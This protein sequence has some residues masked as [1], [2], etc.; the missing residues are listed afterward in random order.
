MNIVQGR[1]EDTQAF[2]MCALNLQQKVLF[3]SQEANSKLQA[4]P[5]LVQT[6]FLLALENGLQ[7]EALRVKLRPFLTEPGI[8]DEVLIERFSTAIMSEEERK[9]KLLQAMH[10]QP[11]TKVNKV[12]VSESENQSPAASHEPVSKRS[13][14]Q[15]QEDKLMAA[16]QAVQQDVNALKERFNEA[17]QN[18]YSTP[19]YQSQGP[20]PRNHRQQYARKWGPPHP[21]RSCPFCREQ[22]LVSAVTT[23]F[24][25]DQPTTGLPIVHTQTRLMQKHLQEMANSHCRGTGNGWCLFTRVPQVCKLLYCVRSANKMAM[26][27]MQS[28]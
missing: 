3:V 21:P 25:V 13:K 15:Q 8:T 11:S 23:V 19:V 18:S 16:I 14:K 6:L 12:F 17:P 27:T 20:R 4:N 26:L 5:D 28:S 10:D 1:R 9:K 2:L 22:K 24:P 7:S